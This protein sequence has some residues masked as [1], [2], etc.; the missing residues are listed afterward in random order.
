MVLS[1]ILNHTGKAPDTALE[2][3]RIKIHIGPLNANHNI[4]EDPA[5]IESVS[6]WLCCPDDAQ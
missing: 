4:A 3:L 6:L 2:R 1:L 5:E